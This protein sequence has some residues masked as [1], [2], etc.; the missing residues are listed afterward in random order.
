MNFLHT[1]KRRTLIFILISN[2]LLYFGFQVWRTMINNFAVEEIGIGPASIGGL[3]ALREVPG[4]MGFLLGF[5]ALFVSEV[6]I[7]SL[8]VIL[9]G[10]G[11]FLTGQ[12]N[13]IPFLFVSAVVMSFG[14]HFFVPC[15]D[16]V[17][18]MAIEKEQTPKTL[19]QLRSLGA[20]AALTGT[21]MVYLLAE[22]WGY[23]TLFMVL[24][25]LIALG[26][27]L[28]LP[29]GGIQEGLPQRRQVILRRRY[30]L[31]YVLAFLMGSRR[32][33]FTTFAIFLL[34]REHGISV[35]T[36]AILFIINSV[37]N[38]Y[39]LQLV[40]KLVGRLGERLMLSIAF[41]ALGFIFLGYAFVTYL[42]L[43][44]VFFVLDNILF[45]FNL[46]LTTY[47]Q[48]IAITQEEITSNLAVQQSINHI[49]A[50][51]VPV[52]GGTA[53]ELFGS[54]A[55]FLAGV[56]IALASLVLVQFMR[57]PAKTPSVVVTSGTKV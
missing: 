6:R 34:V 42:P 21:V 2:F 47:F 17:I 37:V 48:K 26:G 5:L 23:R 13:D 46:A 44:F 39:A 45:G 11:I 38:V 24:G 16:G 22:G 3:Q 18:L 9:L 31:Y 40:G 54:Q 32:H 50:V 25:G 53:W 15:N 1:D 35:Q 8:S 28:L 57:V 29:L 43:L 51:V 55:P 20:I 12:A 30:W 4:L 33:I 36:T 10:A 7:M 41:G 14:F 56:G 19:G 52:I 49:A 27:F